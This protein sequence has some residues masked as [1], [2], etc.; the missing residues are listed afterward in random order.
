MS[1]LDPSSLTKILILILLIV[2]LIGVTALLTDS[3]FE[4]SAKVA[5]SSIIS[6]VCLVLI[7][8]SYL[9][10]LWFKLCV[11]SFVLLSAI[12]SVISTKFSFEIDGRVIMPS[13]ILYYIFLGVITELVGRH[14]EGGPL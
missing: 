9:D 14:F 1:K 10:R 12:L 11:L 6:T 4:F 8:A 3:K 7:Y 5:S 13:A 2:P